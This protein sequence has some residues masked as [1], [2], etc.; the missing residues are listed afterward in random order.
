[1]DQLDM[2]T[3]SCRQRFDVGTIDGQDLVTVAREQDDGGV[4]DVGH[5]SCAEQSTHSS[6][7]WLIK[8]DD[9]DTPERLGQASLTR[10]AAPHLPENSGMSDRNFTTGLGSLQSDPHL[11][12]IALQRHEGSAVEHE[13]HAD[14]VVRVAGRR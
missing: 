3:R 1:M 11:T 5:A 6:S 4:D 9:L 12:F 10:A 2:A 13:R 8:C 14:L 7:E